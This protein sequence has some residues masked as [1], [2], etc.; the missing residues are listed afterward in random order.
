MIRMLRKFLRIDSPSELLVS[1]DVKP[2]IDELD[3]PN[4][5]SLNH[6]ALAAASAKADYAKTAAET[7]NA[8]GS[9]LAHLDEATTASIAQ[10]G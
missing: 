10:S 3:N 8:P 7:R 2:L 1:W 4:Q 9:A 5:W 6:A